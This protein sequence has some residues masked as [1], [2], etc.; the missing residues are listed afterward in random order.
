M[1][2]TVSVN[3]AGFA[4][5]I[6]EQAYEVLRVYLK[7]IR[8]KFQNEEEQDEIMEDIE[9]RVAELFHEKI[10]AI[11]EVITET[12]VQ[13]IMDIMGKPE[14]YLSDEFED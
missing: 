9:A 3:I 8:N 13:E 14:D 12:D 1:N 6:E 5:N 11:K 2:K 4:F 10:S 7:N